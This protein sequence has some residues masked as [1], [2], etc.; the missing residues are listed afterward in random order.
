[1]E[2]IMAS[3][4]NAFIHLPAQVTFA[5]GS[6]FRKQLMAAIEDKVSHLT[7]DLSDTEFMDSAGLGML[8]VALKECELNSISL[9]LRRPKGDI[10]KL[11]ELT[12]S[13]ERFHITY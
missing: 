12:R 10:K 2:L 3:G 8:L 7:I 11:L 9:A 1:M 13:D 6:N 5:D 4:S